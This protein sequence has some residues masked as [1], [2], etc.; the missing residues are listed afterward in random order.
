MEEKEHGWEI[1]L[2]A[3]VK[4]GPRRN[5]GEAIDTVRRAAILSAKD[6]MRTGNIIN[7]PPGGEVLITGDIHGSRE[8]FE[9]LLS[10]ASLHL[11]P[12][13]YLILHELIHG[14]PRDDYGGCLSFELLEEAARLKTQY[15]RQVHILLANHDLAEILGTQL[16]KGSEQLTRAFNEGLDHAYGNSAADVKD[17]YWDLWANLPIA[18]QT[19]NGIFISHSIPSRRAIDYFDYSIF[20][21]PL[22]LED[23]E[24]HSDLYELLWGRNQDQLTADIFAVNVGAEVLINGHQP[25]EPG[26]KVPNTRQIILYSDDKLGRCLLAP[27]DSPVTQGWLVRQIKRI[28]ELPE[29]PRPRRPRRPP[30][31]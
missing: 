17:A 18:A 2:E 23:F 20:D 7:L 30:K 22:V 15:P 24:R 21:R 25:S 9:R 16:T 26:F 19:R 28:V 11:N 3:H 4:A 14:G 29:Q 6:P 10:F 31:R 5:A 12:R 8:N 13:R 27:T 1:D